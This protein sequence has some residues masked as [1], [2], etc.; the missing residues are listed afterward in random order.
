MTPIKLISFNLL[1]FILGSITPAKSSTDIDFNKIEQIKLLYPNE[2]IVQL[3]YQS[4]YNFSIVNGQLKIQ[5]ITN[6][7]VLFVRNAA[8]LYSDR[9]V[10]STSF[11]KAV[12]I[13]ANT[14]IPVNGKYKKIPVTNFT[15]A[16]RADW[17]VFHDDTE[18][19]NVVFPSICDGAIIELN[20]TYEITDAQFIRHILLQHY[21]PTYELNV[22]LN[23]DKNINLG[24]LYFNTDSLKHPFKL[25]ETKSVKQLSYHALQV[26]A[27]KNEDNAPDQLYYIPHILP[28]I[29]SYTYNQQ[30]TPVC[31]SIKQLYKK[32]YSFIKEV[33]QFS[34]PEIKQIADSITLSL[35]DETDKVK[36]LYYWVQENIK[37]IAF[38]DGLGGF[39]PRSPN[40][41]LNRRYGDCKDKST[42]LHALL[43]SENISSR[44]TWVGTRELPYTYES[45]PTLKADNHMIVTYKSDNQYYFLDPTAKYL[46]INYPSSFI[47][48]KEAFMAIDST[49][50]EIVTIPVIAPELNRSI[51][52][53]FF[54]IEKSNLTGSGKIYYTGFKKY[55]TQNLFDSDDKTYLDSKIESQLQKGNNSFV[56]NSYQLDTKERYAN[57]IEL[58][59][60]FIISN[61]YQAIDSEIYINLNLNKSICNNKINP[62]R[63][64]P[65]EFKNQQES[66]LVCSF[67]IPPKYN[68]SY[69]PENKNFDNELA[70]FSTKYSVNQNQIIYTHTLQI[71]TL[72][73]HPEEFAAW[74]DF[75]KAL[76]KCYKESIL[77]TRYET[78]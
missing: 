59:Y 46:T 23:F 77:L 78:N 51:D 35:T 42:L 37:Y 28:L 33:D 53:V 49:N 56:L 31:S 72:L 36:A 29:K 57:Q 47:Q 73:I 43:N 32:Y 55:D 60:N 18:S 7:K 16:D 12:D 75:I 48:G 68:V 52:S 19:A 9:T 14:Y 65:Y 26:P 76:D 41:V 27:C 71:K 3:E 25:T 15:K 10:Y 34:S 11:T 24:L 69:L 44:L 67:S 61:Y 70:S 64:L 39:Y 8:H 22:E 30:T 5:F 45:M 54:T 40:L 6:E 62:K 74:N 38:E 21:L 58:G 17:D 50:Y 20:T 2:N 1:I 4:V 13:K 63:E 66:D